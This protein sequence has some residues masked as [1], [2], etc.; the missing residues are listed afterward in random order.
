MREQTEE[1]LF[2]VLGIP[3]VEPLKRL[4]G[5]PLEDGLPTQ[6]VTAAKWVDWIEEDEEDIRLF[7]FGESFLFGEEPDKLTHG[8]PFKAPETIF[9]DT[10]D[11]RVDLWQTGCM[12]R[13]H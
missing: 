10:Y 5:A 13:H 12:V 6:L 3:E 11:Y 7:D 8:G 4:D 2:A 9:T 1:Q